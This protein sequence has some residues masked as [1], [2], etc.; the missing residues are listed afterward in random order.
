MHVCFAYLYWMTW[1]NFGD[2]KMFI[3]IAICKTFSISRKFHHSLCFGAGTVNHAMHFRSNDCRYHLTEKCRFFFQMLKQE[4]KVQSCKRETGHG[5][6][7]W[8]WRAS[9]QS[10]SFCHLLPRD[11]GIQPTPKKSLPKCPGWT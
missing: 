7:P 10:L 5:P 2:G 8:P 3:Q 11:A 4:P 9:R 1:S 6:F